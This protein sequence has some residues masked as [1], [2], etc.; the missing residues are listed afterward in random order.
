MVFYQ[1]FCGASLSVYAKCSEEKSCGSA[2]RAN[3]ADELHNTTWTNFMKKYILK[4]FEFDFIFDLT[5]S[6]QKG[7]H[8]NLYY[9]IYKFCS[10]ITSK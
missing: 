2:K 10:K 5:F 7:Q 3:I 4:L 9:Q 6:G 8:F 1:D